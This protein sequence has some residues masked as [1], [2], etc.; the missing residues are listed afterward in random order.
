MPAADNG[1][2]EFNYINETWAEQMGVEWEIQDVAQVFVDQVTG[3][4]LP[5]SIVGCTTLSVHRDLCQPISLPFFVFR[6]NTN[7]HYE[8]LILGLRV[9]PTSSANPNAARTQGGTPIRPGDGARVSVFGAREGVPRMPATHG[10]TDAAA[11]SG[12]R[13]GQRR[14]QNR[15]T[16]SGR[17]TGDWSRSV[18]VVSSPVH[19][20]SLA[21]DSILGYLG[22]TLKF[23]L[24][25]SRSPSA[26]LS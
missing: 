12:A 17:A 26:R 23:F 11:A 15:R 9:V 25:F 4:D 13:K 5:C 2:S 21:F 8:K 10:E 22:S 3:L 1:N 7:A 14:K 24:G 19:P 6:L 16:G 20:V 18:I